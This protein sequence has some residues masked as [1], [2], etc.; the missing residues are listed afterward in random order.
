MSDIWM[1]LTDAID[2]SSSI[3]EMEKKYVSTYL[4]LIT[5]T[6]KE[7]VVYGYVAAKVWAPKASLTID[8]TLA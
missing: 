6:G 7:I 5:K 3:Q 8:I 4:V 2:S 1:D